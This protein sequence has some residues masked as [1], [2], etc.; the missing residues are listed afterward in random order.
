MYI[1]EK[2]IDDYP[3][4]ISRKCMLSLQSTMY[5]L[6]NTDINKEKSLKNSKKNPYNLAADERIIL[7]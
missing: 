6:S 3:N 7:T 4:L 2:E 1:K 5:I